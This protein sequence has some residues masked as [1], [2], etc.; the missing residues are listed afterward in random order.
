MLFIVKNEVCASDKEKKRSNPPRKEPISKIVPIDIFN[1]LWGFLRLHHCMR[2]LLHGRQRLK[3][4]EVLPAQTGNGLFHNALSRSKGRADGAIGSSRGT[5][6][7]LQQPWPLRHVGRDPP[8]LVE[9]KSTGGLR[10]QC[11]LRRVQCAVPVIQR[12]P[13]LN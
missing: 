3:G 2:L 7:R 9:V 11:Q 6:L 8:R 12:N 1:A 13:T 10:L 5:R 4:R